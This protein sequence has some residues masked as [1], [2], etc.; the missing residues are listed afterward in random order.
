MAHLYRSNIYETL[1]KTH[2][3]GIMR[4]IKK[5]SYMISFEKR[6][7]DRQKNEK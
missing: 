1:Y 5:A 6:I 4:K 3:Q 2:H 7:D